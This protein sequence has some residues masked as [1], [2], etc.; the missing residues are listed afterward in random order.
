MLSSISEIPSQIVK[1]KNF[2]GLMDKSVICQGHEGIEVYPSER[3]DFSRKI[4]G[5]TH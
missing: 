5:K 2:Q 4:E 1:R 3:K